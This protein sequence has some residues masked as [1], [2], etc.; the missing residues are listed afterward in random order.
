[1]SEDGGQWWFDGEKIIRDDPGTDLWTDTTTLFTTVYA[2]PD[3]HAP[4][5]GKGILK[6]HLL[7]LTKSMTTLEVLNAPSLSVK[8]HAAAR[9]AKYFF[10]TLAHVYGGLEPSGDSDTQTSPRPQRT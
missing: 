1:V 6:V 3:R 10:G 9:C 5:L 2:G 4:V 8:I 7:D